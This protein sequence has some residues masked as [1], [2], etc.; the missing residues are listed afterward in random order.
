VDAVSAVLEPT[1]TTQLPTP[2]PPPGDVVVLHNAHGHGVHQG[3]ALVG[4]FKIDLAAHCGHT[5]A[6]TV[7]GNA[8][9]HALQQ[10]LHLRTARVAKAQGV[11]R[12]HGRAPW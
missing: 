11:Q 12:R 10:V 7:V 3:V 8:V 4:V 5:E 1:Y 2:L 9:H 6:V